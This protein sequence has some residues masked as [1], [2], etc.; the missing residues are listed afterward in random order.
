M[1]KTSS[2]A[3][4]RYL[5][6]LLKKHQCTDLVISPGS[7]NA[8]IIAAFS[9][10]EDYRCYSVPDERVAA[11]TALGMC[12]GSNKPVAIAC[13][14]GSALV[15]YY[16]AITEAFYQKHPL[17]I[18][19]A[20]RPKEWIDQGIGQTIRQ[21]DIFESHI[22]KSVTLQREPQ[23]D[24]AKHYNQ[25]LINEAM[26]ASRQGPV[27][28][29]IPFSEP[30]YDLIDEFDERINFMEQVDASASLAEKELSFLIEDWNKAEKVMVL[31][32]QM[33]PDFELSQSINRLNNKSPFLLLS[34]TLSNIICDNNIT[35]I[36]RL[37]NS[38]QE[39]EKESIKPDL[40]ITIGGEVV[41]KM[42]KKLLRDPKI[43][44]WHIGANEQIKDTFL[45]LRRNVPVT[46]YT[47]FNGL[48]E[49][50]KPKKSD[51]RDSW[52]AK[53]RSKSFH[54]KNYFAESPYSDFKVVGKV[55]KQLPAKSILH[56][57]NS[58]SVRYTQLFDKTNDISYYANRG[59]SGIDGC[60]STAIGHALKS[61]DLVCLISGDIA[62]MYDSNAFWNDHL[63]S[64]LRIIIVNNS[65][66]NIFRII[67]G[68]QKDVSF[69]KFQETHHNYNG[70]S[71]AERFGI[72]Y[73]AVNNESELENALPDF[74]KDQGEVKIMEVFTPRLESPEVLKEYFKY[75]L[76]NNGQ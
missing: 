50:V 37:I 30:L 51:Y 12:K 27:H 67:K 49:G 57:A 76:E 71:I 44:H 47:F 17:I 36:D 25:R 62:F 24:I 58:A 19:S 11:F 63:P 29:N 13:S 38:I 3:N 75:L 45:N 46:P 6:A 8:P 26:I 72:N 32:G 33:E 43:T 35:S 55:L 65:G 5:A 34:E 41:S 40:L 2:K 53:D 16:P 73:A 14:S 54:H 48:M 68:P 10:D 56:T 20:D 22:V 1:S 39:E 64:N 52:L 74:F 42:V 23:D 18:L 59:T 69:E 9:A 31:S 60:T 15:N 7:R 61:K 21:D 66:G 70:K 4:A 28:I